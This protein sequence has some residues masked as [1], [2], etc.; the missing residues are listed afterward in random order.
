MAKITIEILRPKS[1]IEELL[2]EIGALNTALE[3][4]YETQK[5]F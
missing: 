4:E 3:K 5:T 1:L 2:D